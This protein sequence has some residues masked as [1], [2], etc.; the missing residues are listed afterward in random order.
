MR[1]GVIGDSAPGKL[2]AERLAQAGHKFGTAADAEALIL[3]VEEDRLPVAIDEAAG[4][5]S[6]G[7]IVMHT[8]L[9]RGAQAL[10]ALETRGAIVAAVCPVD[11]E[12]W[13]VDA[14]DE[15][16]ETVATLL[17]FEAHGKYMLLDDAD[18]PGFVARLYKRE[19]LREILAREGGGNDY[20]PLSTQQIMAGYNGEPAYLSYARRLAELRGDIEL[21]FWG[22]NDRNQ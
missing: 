12:A 18:R 10:D 9:T 7:T 1:I 8:C 6:S 13:A 16:G 15:L 20:V 5:V 2:F 14:L 21:E 17:V 4:F 3:A 19:M 11:D 22:N